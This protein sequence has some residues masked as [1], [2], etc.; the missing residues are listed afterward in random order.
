MIARI[1]HGWTPADKADAYVEYVKR[2]GVREQTSL[3]GNR[4]DFVLRRREGDRAHFI[5]MSLW[6]SMESVRAFSPDP[7]KAVFYP[8][9]HEYLLELTPGIEHYEVVVSETGQR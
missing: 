2:T 4:G 1:W 9:D 7:E 5:V 6:E 8:E 3:P